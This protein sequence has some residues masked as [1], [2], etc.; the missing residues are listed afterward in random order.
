MQ[1]LLL[2]SA[3]VVGAVSC[4]LDAIEVPQGTAAGLHKAALTAAAPMQRLLA[5]CKAF[6][7]VCRS[8]YVG[9][10]V[11]S[12]VSLR[13]EGIVV[14]EQAE[15]CSSERS[16]AIRTGCADKAEGAWWLLRLLL[17]RRT[18]YLGIALLPVP[19]LCR[20]LMLRVL[21]PYSTTRLMRGMIE[22]FLAMEAGICHVK[23]LHAKIRTK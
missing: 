18:T 20:P 8:I 19:P 16:P 17:T 9:V 15:Q 12:Q 14:S 11:Y 3:A 6:A 21:C 23:L 10:S 2:P 5:P 4:L 13:R 7:F 1:G 22:R